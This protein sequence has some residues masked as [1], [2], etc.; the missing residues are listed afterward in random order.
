MQHNNNILCCKWFPFSELPQ[1]KTAL[2]VQFPNALI[3]NISLTQSNRNRVTLSSSNLKKKK[4]IGVGISMTLDIWRI[5][6]GQREKIQPS[7]KSPQW[8]FYN[9]KY[10]LFAN[11]DFF[12]H[13]N[14]VNDGT[15]LK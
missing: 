6:V 7:Q 4:T 8:A 11:R 5:S 1:F 9:R 2:L 10:F 13:E 14:K 15:E 12:I 3:L